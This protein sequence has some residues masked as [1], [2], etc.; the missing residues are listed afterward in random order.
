VVTTLAANSTGHFIF[1]A[2]EGLAVD[3]SG[4]VYV[5]DRN[6]YQILKVTS[7]GVVST[8]AGSGTTA[9]VD[10]T[11][12]AASFQGPTSVTLDSN[13]NFYVADLTTVRAITPAGVVT[14]LAGNGNSVGAIDAT[15]TYARFS[16]VYAI[17]LDSAGT[18][19]VTDGQFIR[20]ITPSGTVTS[21]AGRYSGSGAA[22]GMGIAARFSS[23]TGIAVDSLG[24]AYVADKSN[25]IIRKITPTG[26]VSTLAGL[27]GTSG[28]VD[29]TG[30]TARFNHPNG[31]AVD[32]TGNVY[33]AD[34][35]NDTIRKIT[36]SGVVTTLAGTAGVHG[37]TDGTGAAAS[38]NTPQG[39][40]VDTVGNVYV[41][42][43]F[44]D[45]IRKITPAG[46]VTTLE[47][48][49][50]GSADGTGTAAK[51]NNPVGVAV[52][53]AGNVFIADASNFAIRK[54]TPAG[55]VTT[56]AS[57][58]FGTMTG[59]TIDSSGNL[60]VADSSHNTIWKVTQ[61]G[62]ASI[63]V[64]TAGSQSIQLGVLPGELYAPQGVAMASNRE[65][66]ITTLSAV[67]TAG[68]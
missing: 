68:L 28:I 7:A 3:A 61:A 10:G 6:Q 57:V 22:D 55:V 38:F 8:F 49:S 62:V 18:I 50:F 58:M 15:G 44:N 20:E 2:P 45:A 30:V 48:G 59:I 54:I 42:D 56:L 53:G 66:Y 33:V 41:A 19:F 34:T 60:Y 27:P 1:D 65:L 17:A 16:S 36:A 5:A 47:G 29:G 35:S 26:I 32:S 14:T 37:M 51:F 40:A 24:N 25:D 11:G 13:G 23:P 4:N 63:V 39:I 46:E 21:F 64:G 12:T 67:L 43:T 52:D 9:T 31:V